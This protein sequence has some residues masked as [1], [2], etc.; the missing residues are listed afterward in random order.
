MGKMFAAA[1]AFFVHPFVH[2]HLFVDEYAVGLRIK[3]AKLFLWWDSLF[4]IINN[5]A[6]LIMEAS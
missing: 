3:A 1:V 4:I 6:E 5:I 2:P